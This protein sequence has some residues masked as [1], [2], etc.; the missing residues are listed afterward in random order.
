MAWKGTKEK[1]ENCIQLMAR[2]NLTFSVKRKRENVAIIY[3]GE[4]ES[5]Y[6]KKQAQ[7]GSLTKEESLM[8]IRLVANSINE[9]ILASNFDIQEVKQLYKNNYTNT[10]TWSDMPIG[11]YF[12]YIDM[13]RAYWSIAWMLTYINDSLYYSYLN[14]PGYKTVLSTALACI[15]APEKVDYYD[16]EI[17]SWR[18]EECKNIHNMIYAN[19]R[20]T[21]W[22]IMGE[23][24]ELLDHECIGYR[25]DAMMVK[26]NMVKS[27]KDYLN[28]KGFLYT[29][30]KCVKVSD[31]YYKVH[32]V[33]FG[34]N[35]E[36]IKRF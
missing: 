17:G 7:V 14:L 31:K 10:E 6:R 32:D 25:T 23:L 12:F 34:Y 1:I 18:I 28:D 30:K 16:P 3:N 27:V 19:I 24:A 36:N 8:V 35:N 4:V 15:I 11:S 22:N 2:N 9:F 33:H 21:C 5:Y 20:H 13:N 26:K 29:V